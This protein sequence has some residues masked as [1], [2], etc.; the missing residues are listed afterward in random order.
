MV[1]CDSASQ[2]WS[3]LNLYLAAQTRAQLQILLQNV[4]KNSLSINDFL[5]KVKNIVDHLASV[6]HTVSSSDHVEAIF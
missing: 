6:G 1:G 3:K 4:K 5:C 2:I